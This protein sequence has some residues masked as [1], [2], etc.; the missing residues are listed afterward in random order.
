MRRGL[1]RLCVLAV[2]GASVGARAET[3]AV[4]FADPSGFNGEAQLSLLRATEDVLRERS[5]LQ[6][7]E[8]GRPVAGAPRRRC[9]ED[10]QCARALAASTKADYA[11]LLSLGASAAG[12][13]VDGLWVE[14]NRTRAVQRKVK[15]V[16]LDAPQPA[17]RELVD[18]L[19][20][21]HLRKGY[22]G[23]VVEAEPG[24]Q[25]KVDGRLL[26]PPPSGEPLPVLAGPHEIDVVWPS[27]QALLQRYEVREGVR[28]VLRP[29]V[30]KEATAPGSGRVPP[31]RVA[32]YATWS[33][34]AVTL[35]A[36]FV[37]A[38]LASTARAKACGADRIC[39]PY[40]MATPE[41]QRALQL[42]DAGN[43]TAGA[44]IGLMAVGAGL[45]VADV[46][47][48]R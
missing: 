1:G 8:Q 32:S 18:G 42:T 39:P 31:L 19:L 48:Q 41:Q 6:V 11:L 30:G 4:A 20:P 7:L 2:V 37:V 40:D 45:F 9:G 26:P 36:S 46:A 10:A 3:V 15:G 24:F 43:I 25:V 22:G 33:A 13:A 17:L 28:N 27:G 47:T 23:L 12:L 29:E 16:S 14:V 35:A 38:G 5:A 34:G 21:P 44:G